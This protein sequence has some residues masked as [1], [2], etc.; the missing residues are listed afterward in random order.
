MPFLDK[1]A[2]L[3][4]HF[5]VPQTAQPKARRIEHKTFAFTQDAVE[6]KLAQDDVLVLRNGSVVAAVGFGSLS[7]SLLSPTELGVRLMSYRDLLRNTTFDFQLLIGTRPQNLSDYSNKLKRNGQRLVQLVQR[8][9]TLMVRLPAYFATT[10]A[11][12]EHFGFAPEDLFGV[13]G[14]AHEAAMTLCD[15]AL[16]TDLRKFSEK[17]RSTAI[18]ELKQRCETSLKYLHRWQELID[19]RD[20][21]VQMAVEGLRAPVRTFYFVTSYNPRLVKTR[22][23]V[24]L[25]ADEIFHAQTELARH[26]DLFMRG[27]QA[28]RLPHWRASHSELQEDVLQFYHP[29]HTQL[30]QELR[31]ERMVAMRLASVK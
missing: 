29:S 15:A 25:S 7:E 11:F 1:I 28:M 3:R 4:Q 5:A 2:E 20:I 14:G 12:G 6:V 27:L 21:Y 13:P 17:D 24:D 23:A 9:D 10:M 22:N 19:A 18:T 16:V 30:A 8:I 31:T 26:C